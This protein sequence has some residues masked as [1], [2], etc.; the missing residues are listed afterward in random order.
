MRWY[1]ETHGTL[2]PYS[3]VRFAAP[4]SAAAAGGAAD[5][6]ALAAAL[7]EWLLRDGITAQAAAFRRGVCAFVQPG[8]LRPFTSA[9]REVL[10]SGERTV[11]WDRALLY[12][13]GVKGYVPLHCVR[14]LL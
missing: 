4:L 3:G 9:E 8:A 14:I 2:C 7:G 6:V 12:K 11:V 1:C 10:I 13:V 5:A